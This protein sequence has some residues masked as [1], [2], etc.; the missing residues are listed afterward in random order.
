[1]IIHTDK[2][3]PRTLAHLRL[4]EDTIN[5]LA[6]IAN[7]PVTSDY[8]KNDDF[9]YDDGYHDGQRALARL[10]L[11]TDKLLRERG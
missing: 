9:N 4:D 11:K 10:L 5:L 6:T 1:M 7:Q 2:S 8:K 3:T